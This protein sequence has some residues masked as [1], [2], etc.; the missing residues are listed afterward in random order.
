[1]PG[2]RSIEP[3][4]LL[5]AGA[6]II[7]LVAGWLILGG[8]PIVVGVACLA[9]GA[10]LGLAA[11]LCARVSA[12]RHR[13][14]VELRNQ[15]E[16]QRNRLER[17]N[18]ALDTLADGL[19]VAVILCD[20]RGFVQFANRKAKAMFRADEPK[21]EP[22]VAITLSHELERLVTETLDTRRHTSVEMHFTYPEDRIAIVHAWAEPPDWERVYV[23]IHDVTELRRLE[24]I[25]QDFV[26]NV[27]HEVRTPMTL[28]RAMAET[29]L[30]EDGS[31]RDLARR[32]LERIIAEVDRLTLIAQDL[33]VLSSAE[34]GIVRKQACDVAAVIRG[35]VSLLGDKAGKKAL[36]IRY[37]GPKHFMIEANSAQMSQV[38]TNLIDNAINY[39]AEGGIEVMMTPGEKEVTVQVIDTGVGIEAEHLPRIFERFYRVDKA[40]SRATGGTGLGLSI[41][42]HIVES[43]GG[44]VGVESAPGEGSAFTVVLPIGSPKPTLDERDVG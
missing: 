40:R 44:R 32:Y 41:V 31:D 37:E 6:A 13:E 19:D 25:R 29:L 38:F 28:I 2:E 30:D 15:H 27:S 42:R 43:H 21:G 23:S 36:T 33:L 8:H 35:I 16:F 39:T 18:I 24:R 20:E 10:L 22:I 7:L 3:H 11:G 14:L 26:A 17:L 12:A 5:A 1:V 34:T 4:H 9:V